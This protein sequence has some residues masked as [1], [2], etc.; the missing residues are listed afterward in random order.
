M[1]T[2]GSWDSPNGPASLVD[3]KD[4]DEELRYLRRLITLYRG[5]PTIRNLAVQI[6]QD[7]QA[8]SR[9][10]KA[11]AL[12]IG[13]WVQQN[14]Y[15]VH[16]LPERFQDPTE[17]LRLKA[18]DCDDMTTLIGSLLESI[19][20]SSVM[21]CM[22]VNGLWSHIYP[23]ARIPETGGLLPLDATMRFAVPLANNPI[24]WAKQR[25]KNVAIKLA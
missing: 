3:F 5:N 2:L 8:P 12:A 9:D 18:G 24:E 16:E 19:G 13:E 25:G 15:Y 20:I 23:A 1:R 7:T 6:I 21:V 11:Q 14:I 4:I 17:T 10:K 22:K